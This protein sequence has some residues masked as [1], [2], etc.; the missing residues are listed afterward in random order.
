[1]EAEE[2][3]LLNEILARNRRNDLNNTLLVNIYLLK[4]DESDPE[5]VSSWLSL[6]ALAV[7]INRYLQQVEPSYPW[8]QGGDGPVFGVHLDEHENIPHLRAECRYDVSVADAWALIRLVFDF[9]QL[10]NSNSISRKMAIECWDIDDGHVILIE[11]APVL[12][13]WVEE[14]QMMRHRCWILDGHVVLLAP[15]SS[16]TEA[17]GSI[18]TS[19]TRRQALQL[20]QSSQ[21][22]AIFQKFPSI[23]EMLQQ[24]LALTRINLIHRAA[25]A[26]P[27]S[28]AHLL[29]QQPEL[30]PL[31]ISAWVE[32]VQPGHHSS[33]LLSQSTLSLP[34]WSTQ[35]WQWTVQT[36]PRLSYAQSRTLTAPDGDWVATDAVPNR[37][38][39]PSLRRLSS[40]AKN[41]ATPHLQ[42]GVALGVR[43]V[44]GLEQLLSASPNSK[45]TTA[46]SNIPRLFT[47]DKEE[48]VLHYWT[49]LVATVASGDWLE[50]AWWAGPQKAQHS[51]EHVLECPVYQPEVQFM[52][53]P[54]K[55]PMQSLQQVVERSWRACSD[56]ELCGDGEPPHRQRVDV[57]E[58]WLQVAEDTHFPRDSSN[59]TMSDNLNP[60]DMQQVLDGFRSFMTEKSDV[61]GIDHKQRSK[62]EGS[63]RSPSHSDKGVALRPAAVLHLLRETLAAPTA[64]DLQKFLSRPLQQQ[65][66]YFSPQDY[67][68][69]EPD[70]S[71]DDDEDDELPVDTEMLDIM[72]Q[73]DQELKETT[74][75]LSRNVDQVI[76]GQVIEDTQVAEEAHIVSNLMESVD[77]SAGAP[78]PVR[79]ILTEMGK[80][81]PARMTK[82]D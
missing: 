45:A 66:Q 79:N 7:E 60:S 3:S 23:D 1:M 64:G 69:M 74:S 11:T 75:N 12:P 40:Q 52:P 26:L 24:R 81:F 57:D 36:Y 67:S 27:V 70:A 42:H 72:E 50:Q 38:N 80:E 51:L 76:D 68:L 17:K 54:L 77:A 9:K 21:H 10:E 14:P 55:F 35:H 56:S 71:D 16:T 18:T 30:L 49:R 53:Y 46:Q 5:R 58:A 63:Q 33:N 20:L 43:L 25:V 39:S 78:G 59:A 4:E 62:E 19:L 34:N 82:K 41:S 31:F 29:Q 61:E 22:T 65:D 37:F 32:S 44:A 15:T 13:A 73:M 28:V 6:A 2:S 47:T 8:L 48:R